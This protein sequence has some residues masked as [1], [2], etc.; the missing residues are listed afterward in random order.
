MSQRH[1]RTDGRLGAAIDDIAYQ[2]CLR[3]YKSQSS[4]Y[5]VLCF[6]R[7]TC[8]LHTFIKTKG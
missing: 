2:R 5:T 6:Y 3:N 4:E 7:H 8:R 1:G